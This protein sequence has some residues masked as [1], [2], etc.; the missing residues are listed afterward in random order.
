MIVLSRKWH[1]GFVAVAAEPIF[2]VAI[3]PKGGLAATAGADQVIHLWDLE[4]GHSGAVLPGHRGP[5]WALAFSPDGQRLYSAGA[6][7]VVRIWDLPKGEEIGR[8]DRDLANV[9]VAL[10][11]DDPVLLR[12]AQVFR[13]CS[14]CHALRPGSGRRAG[15]NLYGVFGRQA[16]ALPNYSYSQALDS[17]DIVWDEH[18]IAQLFLEG[19]DVFTPGTKM[20]IQRLTDPKDIE[21]LL[22]YLKKVAEP[23]N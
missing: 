7:E 19:P 17:S 5:I 16:G 22:A 10:E 23:E 8:Y 1:A 21:A 15:P 12:G 2:A 4:T 14:V 3:S 18:S 11:T 13:K 6:D 9:E 20:P